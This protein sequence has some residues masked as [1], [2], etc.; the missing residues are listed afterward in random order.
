MQEY[1]IIR[2]DESIIKVRKYNEQEYLE[3]LSKCGARILINIGSFRFLD[4]TDEDNE[5]HYLVLHFSRNDE[6]TEF[7]EFDLKS[8]YDFLGLYLN[9][10]NIELLLDELCNIVIV[11]NSSNVS[12]NINIETDKVTKSKNTKDNNKLN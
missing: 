3:S 8:Y 9:K 6:E 10:N 11:T 2:Y 1:S 7:Y 5:D 4:T 12:P